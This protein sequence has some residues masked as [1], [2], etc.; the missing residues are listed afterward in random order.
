MKTLKEQ[1][2]H[3]SCTRDRRY[4]RACSMAAG[5]STSSTWRRNRNKRSDTG[6]HLPGLDGLN[7]T[8]QTTAAH[9]KDH[10]KWR[11]RS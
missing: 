9:N 2:P 6:R 1:K 4:L 8:Q 7:Q 3:R 5:P 10:S 11:F